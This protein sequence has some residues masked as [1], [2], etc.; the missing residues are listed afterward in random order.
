MSKIIGFV[1]GAIE[2]GIGIY[3]GNLA[4]IVQGTLTIIAQAAVDLTATG[5]PARQASETQIQLG[6][7]PRS[8]FLGEGW[9]AGSLVDGF[10]FGGKYGTDWEVLIIRLADEPCEALTQYQVDDTFYDYAG[11]GVQPQFDHH[12]ELYFRANTSID[13]LPAIVTANWPG[14]AAT[15]IG[16]SGCDVIVAYLADSPSAKHPV[17]PGG[18]PKFG[19]VLKGGRRYDPRKDSTVG[20]SGTHRRDDPS[21]WEWSENAEVCRYNWELGI[22]ADGH[23]NDPTQ[24]LV[25]RGLTMVEAPPANVFAPAN[26]CD[27]VMADG[28]PRYRVAG[29]IYSNQEHI[30]VEKMFALATGGITIT[31]EGAVELEP[32][33]AKSVVATFTDDDL[34]VGTKVNYNKGI[35]SDADE[36]W[37]NTV[38]ARYVEPAQNWNDFGAPVVRS[39][40]DIIADGKPRE[41]SLPLRLVK[42]QGQALRIAEMVRRKGRLWKRAAV[43]LGPRFCRLEEGDWVA[44]QSDSLFAGATV[45]FR[46]DAYSRDQKWQVTFTLS[47]IAASVYGD[48]GVF[49]GDETVTGATVP[50]PDI[51]APDAANWALAP[52]TLTDN[53]V[54]TGAIE[55]TGSAADDPSV[56]RIVVEYWKS[57]GIIDPIANPDDP[58]WT[59]FGGELSPA[60]TKVD[61]TGLL[62]GADYYVSIAYIVS[63]IYGDRLVLGPETVPSTDVSGAVNPIVDAKLGKLSW[64]EPVRAKTAAALAANTYANGASGVGATLTATANGAL[65]NQDGVALAAADR[66][67]V[68]NEAAGAHNGIYA[69]TQLGDATHPY[70]LTR[71]TD[72]DEAGELVNAAVKIS[73][74]TAA[75]DEEY[76]CTTNGPITVGTTAL[77]WTEAGSAGAI[78]IQDE[79]VAQGSA[80]T[81]NFTGAGV[82][83]TVS[84]GVAS[85]NIP[86]GGAGDLVKIAE[87]VTSG[88]ATNVSFTAIPAIYR[89][90]RLCVHGRGTKVATSV[91]VR[92]RFNGDT[93]NDY[94]LAFGQGGG[95]PANVAQ[96]SPNPSPAAL[97]IGDFAAA[98]A[99]ANVADTCSFDIVGYASTVFHKSMVG[100]VTHKKGNSST[101]DIDVAFIAGWWRN[102]AAINQIDV[103][104]SSG[105]FVNG[106]TVTL[107]ALK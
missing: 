63:G 58:P 1:V 95:D 14:F 98:S 56:A 19:F 23:V 77:V 3:T 9:T 30:D 83:S 106:T 66:L 94:D 97:Y 68:A 22:F 41:A 62:G 13:P 86:G 7:Q 57:D 74:G 53:G 32:G 60:T 69:V 27:E 52:V 51:G 61:I 2:V 104:P 25:G 16:R 92:V 79:G 20:G 35:P 17:W 39:T 44:W 49:N 96:L 76:Q 85:V 34:V 11:D 87:V 93:G 103:F 40:A 18:R 50:P 55:L 84:G 12:F 43:T 33:Q 67:L 31:H 6:E 100:L 45:T 64:K 72:A 101:L 71:A 38:V 90:L 80:S 65:A 102:T 8:M 107:Y 36:E 48:D 24:L 42:D 73:E 5:T 54:S 37:V 91:D 99:P 81:V 89:A 10:D 28:K 78:A 105:A 26:L 21:T 88:S 29:P 47:E 70:I 59:M 46:I 75:A 15:D 82:T 4:L